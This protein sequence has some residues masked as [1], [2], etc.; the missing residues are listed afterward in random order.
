MAARRKKTQQSL[1]YEEAQDVHERVKYLLTV[2]EAPWIDSMRIYCFRTYHSSARAYARIR[3]LDRI[4]QMAIAQRPAYSIEVIS[5]YFDKLS[6]QRKD[7]VLLHEL[8]HI[9]QTFSGAL[10]PH[11]HKGKG[12]FHGKLR[13]LL[14][15]YKRA[16]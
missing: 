4:W 2:I 1:I 14:T 16:I 10:L 5:E 13:Q 6:P 7:E 8:C 11:T 9:P 12:S 3:G 15:A